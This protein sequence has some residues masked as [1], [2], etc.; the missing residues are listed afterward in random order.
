MYLTWLSLVPPILV[1]CCAYWL[2]QLNYAILIGLCAA[3]LIVQNGNIGGAIMILGQKIWAQ[4]TNIDLIYLYVFLICI[5]A[6]IQLFIVTNS[7]AA[8]TRFI[9]RKIRSKKGIEL[10]CCAASSGLSIDDYLSILTVGNVMRSVTDH[11]GIARTKLAYLIHSFSGAIVILC[12]ISSWVA[13]IIVYLEQSG[14]STTDSSVLIFADPFMAYIGTIPYMAYSLLTIL[15][16]LTIIIGRISFGPMALYEKNFHPTQHNIKSATQEQQGNA[17][18]LLLPLLLLLTTII[19]GILYAGD[20]YLLGGHN[21]LIEAFKNSSSI[22]LILC[23]ASSVTLIFALIR[24]VYKKEIGIHQIPM[25]ISSG[26]QL[27]RTVLI[28]IFLISLLS[29]FLKNELHTGLYLAH[30]MSTAIM[31]SLLPV[32]MFLVALSIALATGSSWGTFGILLPI[33]VPLLSSISAVDPLTP[34]NEIPLLYPTLG[35]IFSG[36][37]CGDHV[38]LFSETTGMSAASTEISP[39]VHFKTQLPY[40]IPV[41]ISTGVCYL[42]MGFLYP[43]G[44]TFAYW[45]P[46]L[47]SAAICLACIAFLQHYYKK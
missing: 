5:P 27:M 24:S 18:D 47:C 33:A 32:T 8:F 7:A 35:A 13:T 40:A 28:M 36:A 15:T 11:V 45:L 31:S 1:V 29:S 39:L 20:F 21:S 10:A 2:Q 22:F 26:F 43:Y 17:L 34:L 30:I 25:V 9:T 46:M 23:I 3:A 16:V 12:P 19:V 37:V 42:M 44:I 38:S 14:I 6:L 41:I 4:C